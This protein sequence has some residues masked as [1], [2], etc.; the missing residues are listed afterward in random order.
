MVQDEAESLRNEFGCARQ[1]GC[2]SLAVVRL[3]ERCQLE[4]SFLE[5][6]E[7]AAFENIDLELIPGVAE[8]NEGGRRAVRG[9]GQL[10]G[11]R[12]PI[13]GCKLGYELGCD[14]ARLQ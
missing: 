1:L 7:R 14:L 13:V 3:E 9:F 10:F 12:C 8:S 2:E 4:Q 11:E 5:R 6:I